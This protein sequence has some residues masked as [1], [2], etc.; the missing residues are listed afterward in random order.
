MAEFELDHTS[1]PVIFMIYI[2]HFARQ[3][4]T[5]SNLGTTLYPLPSSHK[6][7][8]LPPPVTHVLGT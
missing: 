2:L 8:S 7:Y 4:C 1:R 6:V 3:P 5:I